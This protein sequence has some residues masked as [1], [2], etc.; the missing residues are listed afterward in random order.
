MVENGNRGV[1]REET[2]VCQGATFFVCL[3]KR[4]ESE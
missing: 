2:N 3:T 1:L 4:K